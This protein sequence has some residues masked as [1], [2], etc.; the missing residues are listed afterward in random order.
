MIKKTIPTS[1]GKLL[2]VYDD[3][4]TYNE[5]AVFAKFVKSSLFKVDGS[6]YDGGS[7]MQFFSAY[8]HDDVK[9]MGL[10][11]S[12]GFK[13]INEEHSLLDRPLKQAR[14][15]LSPPGDHASIHTDNNGLTFLYYANLEWELDWGGHTLFM[16]DTLS[17]AEY[18]CLYKPGRVVVFDGTIPH[19]IQNPSHL[20]KAHRFS[21]AIQVDKLP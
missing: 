18:T 11:D 10:L 19:M 16:D 8:S 5:R 20:A 17:E 7:R 14:V 9:N 6:D 3:Y 1:T 12:E 15:N 4:F 2:E 13:K 21:F